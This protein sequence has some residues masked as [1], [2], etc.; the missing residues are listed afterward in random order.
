MSRTAPPAQRPT[1]RVGRRLT[2]AVGAAALSLVGLPALAPS[3]GAASDP[4]PT[5]VVAYTFDDA[6]PGVATL[7]NSGSGGAK[8]DGTVVNA[9]ALLSGSRD[10]GG[11]LALPGGALGAPSASMPY[12]QI[13]NGV[14][15]GISGITVSTWVYW[16]GKNVTSAAAPWTYI[17]GG[18][19]LPNNNYGVFFAPSENGKVTV[20]ANDGPEFKANSA[21]ALPANTWTHVAVTEDGS[22]LVLYV[23]GLRTDSRPS[24]VDFSKLYSASSTF[25]GLIGR[26][27]WTAQ[28]ASYFGGQLDDFQVYDSALTAD[29]VAQVAGDV[30]SVT[31]L[32][33][34]SFALATLAGTAPS[35]PTSVQATYSDGYARD[36]AATWDAV[37]PSSYAAA[38]HLTVHGTAAGVD[39]TA[40]V[41]VLSPDAAQPVAH[42]TFDAASPSGTVVDTSGNGLDATLV[43]PGTAT[44][45]AGAGGSNAL[46]LPGGASGSTTAAYVSLPRGVLAGA[47][48][49]TVS[50]RVRWGGGAAWQRFFDL[51]TNSTSYLFSTPSNGDAL[52]SAVTTSGGGG[53]ASNTG[54]AALP[55]GSWHTVT[56]VLDTTADRLTTYLD[57]AA[58]DT[59]PT[60]LTAGQLLSGSATSSGALGKSFYADPYFGGAYD[61]VAIYRAALTPQQVADAVLGTVPT[62]TG[63]TTSTF[64][65]ATSIGTAP[66]LPL[67][68][69]ATYSDGYTRNAPVTWDAVDPTAY[70]ARGQLTVHGTAA[71]LD[72]TAHVTVKAENEVDIDLSQ[73]TGR[74]MGG[75][76]GTLYGL[77]GQGIP[78][79]NVID[80]IKLRTVATKAQDG[81]QHPGADALEV[82]KPLVDSSGG[83]VY[84]YMTDIYR[85]FPY[86]W[87]G[88]SPEARLNDYKAK[89]ATEVDQVAS[90]PEKYRSHVVFVP[91]NEPEGNMFGTG[92]WSYNGISWTSD[93]QYYFAAWDAVHAIIKG[94]IPDA[95]I[96]GP[97]TSVLYSQVQGFI[98]HAL[99]A[100]T[101]PDVITWHELSNPATIRSNVAKFRSWETALYAGTA[102]AGRHLPI[103]IDE[104]AYNYHTSVPGQMIQWISA[105][106]DAK[107]DGDVAYWNIDG[108]ISDTAVQANRG[109]G[110]WWLFNAYGQMTGD[111]VQLTPPRPG[112]NYTLQGV[113]TLDTSKKQAQA[114]IGGAS[115]SS[116]VSFAH[117]DPAV[118][119]TTAHVSVKEIRWSGQVGDN[120]GPR[121]VAELNLPVTDGSL[122]VQL[123]SGDL[124]ALNAESAYVITVTPGAHASTSTTRPFLWTGTYEAEDAAH[125]GTGWSK[126]GPEGTTSNVS[127]FYTSGGYD[128]GGLRTGSDVRLS[129]TV[130]VPHDGKYDLSVFANSLNTYPAVAQQGPTNV[131][132]TV[133]GAAEQQLYLPLA[134]KWVVW[135]HTDTTVDLTAGKHTLTLAATSLDGTRSTTGDAIVDKIDLALPNP[136]AKDAVYEG[137]NAELAGGA[138]ADY[139]QPGVSGSGTARLAVGGS[140]TFWVYSPDDAEHTLS[141]D[142]LGSGAATLTVNAHDVTAL[143]ASSQLPVFLDGGINKVT[144]TG[145]SGA[146]LVDR[147]RV[148]ASTAALASTVYP[149]EDATTSGTAAVQPYPLAQGGKAVTG[150]GGD[151]GNHNE[152]TFHV[153][154]A[155]A[156]TY[157]ITV[158]YSNGEQSMA[159]HYNPDPLAR[160]ADVSVNGAVAQRVWFP[161]TFHDDN[162]WDETFFATLA[163][164]SNTLTFH[165]EELPSFDGKTYLSQTFP[166]ADMRSPWAPNIDQLTVT[167]STLGE[168]SK[169]A[170]YTEGM[171]VASGGSLWRALWWTQNQKPGDPYGPWEQIVT[172]PD[173]TAVWTATRI[174]DT[175]DRVTY[176]GTTYV[177]Q[178]WTRNQAPGD[179][180]GP[181]KAAG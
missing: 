179:P 164:G 75:A 112:V 5:P 97:N 73:D 59:A 50:A 109:N 1:A 63:L 47:T 81:V 27:Q 117:V 36:V 172:A 159:S 7:H 53:E 78:S 88:D 105:L 31:G 56:V 10:G 57:G 15:Q 68:A 104:Y 180:N 121:Q 124:P 12:V 32:A 86:E 135:D 100:G 93:P 70:A 131:F 108:N 64:D 45:V 133:D 161:H 85:G 19:Q 55:T 54:S 153:T 25:S 113:A 130:D 148:G 66:S 126:N 101:M 160:H 71:S 48:D 95:R 18:D 76:V 115:G 150:I 61:D 17:L 174:F 11:T 139:T 137:E 23:N 69:P 140:A 128:V 33:S 106:E 120:S 147:V 26:T 151:P 169:S 145:T 20:A 138:T 42:Y 91:F 175:G 157:A 2:A 114:I 111:T 176:R 83:D 123:G 34:T 44:V 142:A 136:A 99:A 14:Y 72:V 122:A 129:F 74:F 116:L 158:R 62:A 28:Y 3:A 166:D 156:G 168:W 125:T 46:Q 77:Y 171:Q 51:G 67:T 4:V 90:L 163:K 87:P 82:V 143:T 38:G 8:Y 43:N 98:Q 181:W 9:S 173:G 102:Y 89:I 162:F 40:T 84:I 119:G 29:Q 79:N 107:V 35:L 13:P 6:G 22:N 60:T 80:G 103:N 178:W 149:A 52:R 165:S 170:V 127:G 152:L 41:T 96:A 58:V 39:L 24:A 132:L 118:F 94:K 37:D 92:T 21:N 134:Y 65:V 154:A 167:P 16:D 141:V 30:P 146:L 155:A 177:A 110:Q 144:V 49:L